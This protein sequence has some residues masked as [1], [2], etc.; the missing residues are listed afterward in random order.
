M[1]KDLLLISGI[2]IIIFGYV[3]FTIVY[4]I[5]RK[6]KI[7]T[8]S[9]ECALDLFK[10]DNSIKIIESND[11]H[12][13]K[14]NIKRDIVKLTSNSYDKNDAFSVST[15]YFLSLYA[16]SNNK[17]L[18]LLGKIISNIKVISFTPIV[19]IFT[20]VICNTPMDS[21]IGILILLLLG[22]YQYMIDSI[23][24]EIVDNKIKDNEEVNNLVLF[25]KQTN[26][27]FFISTLIE[28]VRLVMILLN[29]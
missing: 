1:I 4:L 22:A 13:S 27:L 19:V 6:Q 2:V 7:N 18:E 21:K 24:M 26:A 10:D 15:T 9:L 17:Y 14:Y 20:S 29:I 5:K 28:L 23:N 25:F 16:S 3:K 11:S 8:N 12:F